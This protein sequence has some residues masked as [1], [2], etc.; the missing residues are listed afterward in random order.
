M[1][2][3]SVLI[4]STSPQTQSMKKF[5]NV[6]SLALRQRRLYGKPRRN[7]TGKE[8]DTE[9]GLYYYGA[10]YLD[11]KASRWLSGDPALGEYLPSA[12]V[13]EEA[14]KRNGNLPGMGGVFNYV[15]LHVYHYAGNNPVR[16]ID[17]DGKY[18]DDP[19]TRTIYV[20]LDDRLDMEMAFHA[21]TG[22]RNNTEIHYALTTGSEY[23]VV[24][25]GANGTV[26]FN[27]P[28]SM[29][30]YIG[31]TNPSSGGFILVLGFGGS[32]GAATST[33]AGGGIMIGFSSEGVKVYGYGEAG[34]TAV[35]ANV[36][37]SFRLGI[38]VGTGDPSKINGISP[39]FGFSLGRGVFGGVDITFNDNLA[40]VTLSIGLTA[41]GLPLDIHAGASGIR[42]TRIWESRR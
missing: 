37:G 7:N 39:T 23:K 16:Y 33:N 41:R 30:R 5:H 36:S 9:T 15:N 25:T 29:D 13:N 6:M 21:F 14:R 12:P 20:N 4:L 8:S 34:V 31:F 19:N 38:L 2:N 42:T 28:A 26:T 3:E 40:G 11:P 22:M 18:E 35:L 1:K 24:A 27:D 10:R 17:P 32:V